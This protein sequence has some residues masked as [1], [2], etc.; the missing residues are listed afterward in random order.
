VKEELS[1]IAARRSS[2]GRRQANGVSLTEALST[3]AFW[4]LVNL[5]LEIVGRM[6]KKQARRF[7]TVIRRIYISYL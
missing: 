4:N 2:V 1:P 6:R 5:F 7:Y 3:S